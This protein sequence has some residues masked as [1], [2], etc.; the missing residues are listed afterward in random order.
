MDTK[1]AH[2]HRDRPDNKFL[3]MSINVRSCCDSW[4]TN[5]T[6]FLL[7]CSPYSR[8]F[9]VTANFP[10]FFYALI[11]WGI[12]E[13]ILVFCSLI[14]NS[15]I[16]G[17]REIFFS[18]AFCTHMFLVKFWKV[19]KSLPNSFAFLPHFIINSCRSCQTLILQQ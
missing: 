13:W 1:I 16:F 18:K 10:F 3:S 15:R 7:H 5:I 9:V 14:H 12:Y 2:E 8:K 6:Q 17:R 11:F 4:R 19:T